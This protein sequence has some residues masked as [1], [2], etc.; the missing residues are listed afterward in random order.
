MMT[1]R[2]IQKIISDDN[3]EGIKKEWLSCKIKPWI[4]DV[5]FELRHTEREP[6]SR[7]GDKVLVVYLE[8]GA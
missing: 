6:V 2:K 3:D 4:D 5:L 1:T 7:C 8:W